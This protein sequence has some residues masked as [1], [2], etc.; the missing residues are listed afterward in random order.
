MLE[1]ISR[2]KPKKWNQTAIECYKKHCKC[3][4]CYIYKIYFATR[5]ITCK[6]KYY[7][8]EMLKLFGEPGNEKY[9]Y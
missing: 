4:E 7:V 5:N 8:I 1:T 3:S 9:K 6:M 2:K